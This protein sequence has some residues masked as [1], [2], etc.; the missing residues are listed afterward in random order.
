MAGRKRG[1]KPARRNS[2]IIIATFFLDVKPFFYNAF[3]A[4]DTDDDGLST[5][6]ST[7]FI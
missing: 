6:Y 3:C 4:S 5:L 2:G 7:I 1:K